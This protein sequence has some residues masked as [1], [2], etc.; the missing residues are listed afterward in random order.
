MRRPCVPQAL[1]PR[2]GALD[3]TIDPTCRIGLRFRESLDLAAGASWVGVGAGEGAAALSAGAAEF[4]AGPVWAADGAC[5]KD[6][7]GIARKA[8]AI[9]PHRNFK[10]ENTTM[11]SK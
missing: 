9:A 2:F 11:V 1:N 6:G 3:G 10:R 8:S 5:A 7:A 4:R